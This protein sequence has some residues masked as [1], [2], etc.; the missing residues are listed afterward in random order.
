M[1]PADKESALCGSFS[2]ISDPHER[3]A[4]IV[5]ACTGGG[6]PAEARD[7]EHLVPGCVS[8]VWLTAMLENGLLQLHWQADSPLVQGLAGLVCQ[9]YDG[10]PPAAAGA[11][12]TTVLDRLGLTRQISPTRLH[13]LASVVRR[14]RELARLAASGS[15]R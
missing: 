10:T 3:L 5:A 8:R 6:V 1:S 12:E 9:V 14:I 4:A 7:E 11:F 15:E 13:G 2:I